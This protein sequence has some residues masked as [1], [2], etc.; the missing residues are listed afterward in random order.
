MYVRRGRE[1]GEPGQAGHA[2]LIEVMESLQLLQARAR[3][4]IVLEAV[5]Y[6]FELIPILALAGEEFIEVE[7]HSSCRCFTFR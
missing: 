3:G 7:D 5:Q 6:G 2:A 4:R 1:R